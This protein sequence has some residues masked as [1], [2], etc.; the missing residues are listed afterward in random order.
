M[1]FALLNWWLGLHPTWYRINVV[2]AR[3]LISAMI[4]VGALWQPPL[5][6]VIL[7]A[8]LPHCRL[9]SD[10]TQHYIGE[11]HQR[12]RPGAAVRQSGR[13]ARCLLALGAGT[14]RA[15]WPPGCTLAT[16]ICSMVFFKERER[17]RP[18][19]CSMVTASWSLCSS[20]DDL[21]YPPSGL[22]KYLVFLLRPGTK[23]HYEL[24]CQVQGYGLIF[25]FRADW[26][27]STA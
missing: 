22:I 3:D 27:G 2:D 8:A 16:H 15:T 24:I 1:K 12:D 26:R 17:E 6:T 19:H 14:Q 13:A 7:A 25:T 4:L 11:F 21:G 9:A 10:C 20:L 5:C 23:A 18:L